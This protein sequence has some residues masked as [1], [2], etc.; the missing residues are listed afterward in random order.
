MYS[1]GKIKE[2]V[3]LIGLTVKKQPLEVF[4][5]ERCTIMGLTGVFIVECLTL[6][7]SPS[8]QM[9]FKRGEGPERKVCTFIKNRSQHRCFPVKFAKF[10]RTPFLQS[11]SGGCFWTSE[12]LQYSKLSSQIWFNR[13][14]TC[15]I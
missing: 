3:V 12:G 6:R 5:E 8:P 15:I 4:F 1:W 2:D 9:F 14:S 7:S 11:T 10:L 13:D